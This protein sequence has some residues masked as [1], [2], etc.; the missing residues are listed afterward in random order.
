MQLTNKIDF[1]NLRDDLF[2]GTPTLSFERIGPMSAMITAVIA[3]LAVTDP[4][5]GLTMALTGVVMAGVF[6]IL[7]GAL[8]L[9]EY[10]TIRARGGSLRCHG[11]YCC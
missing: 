8:R 9:G 11:L 6:Q 3:N 7:L 4:D 5:N 1:R 2:G 10:V